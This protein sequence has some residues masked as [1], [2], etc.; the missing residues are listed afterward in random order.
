MITATAT[1][2]DQ[3]RLRAANDV[4]REIAQHGLVLT[5]EQADDLGEESLAW[6]GG[7]LGL[8]VEETDRGVE[9][10]PPVHN[11][12]RDEDGELVTADDVQ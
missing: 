11:V 6:L 2:I 3:I 7:R 4:T 8:S 9:C 1:Q 10:T 12:G 5:H